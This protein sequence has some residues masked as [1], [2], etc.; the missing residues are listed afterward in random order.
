MTLA[1]DFIGWSCDSHV[2]SLPTAR[3]VRGRGSRGSGT[4]GGQDIASLQQQ[5][6]EMK[7]KV[8]L[9]YHHN[10]SPYFM[11]VHCD[12]V[13]HPQMELRN[14]CIYCDVYIQQNEQVV[15][16]RHIQSDYSQLV[17]Q[18]SNAVKGCYSQIYLLATISHYC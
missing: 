6:Q 4:L 8:R 13:E 18:C 3:K 9:L 1:S 2:I 10:F 5:L 12:T 14:V 7:D 16:A 15:C 17:C 11:M